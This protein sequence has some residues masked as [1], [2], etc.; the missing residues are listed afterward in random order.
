MKN[1]ILKK[2]CAKVPCDNRESLRIYY[3]EILFEPHN[4]DYDLLSTLRRRINN[5]QPSIKYK[6]VEG[7]QDEKKGK[8]D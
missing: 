6:W 7:H 5:V 1:I 2:H 4:K 3:K 8:N